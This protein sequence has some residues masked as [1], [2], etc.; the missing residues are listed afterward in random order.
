MTAAAQTV[1]ALIGGKWI[2]LKSTRFVEVFNP[3]SG[4]VLARTPLGSTADA[5]AAVSAAAEALPAWS[6]TPAVDR[7]RVMFAYRELLNRHHDELARLVTREHGKTH[8]EAVAE[9]QRGLEV[10]EFACGV[11]SLLAG[12]TFPNLAANVDGETNRHPVGVCVGITPYNFPNM[13][14]LWMFPIALVCGNTFVL[15]PSEKVPLSAI[16]LGELLIEAGLPAGVFNIVHGDKVVVDALLSD[17]RVAAVSFVGS[18]DIA[19][20]I[21][22]TAAAH[23]KRVQSAGGAK[24]HLIIMP[25][26]DLDQSVKALAA[27]AFGCAG[28]RCMAGSVA[29]AVGDVGDALVD[30]LVDYSS[31]MTVGP[32]DGHDETEMGPLIN[33]AHRT[34]VAGYLD[35]AKSEGASV[36]L[37]GREIAGKFDGFVLGPCVVDEVTPDMTLWRNEIFGPVLSVVRAQTLDDALAIGRACPFGNGAS[38]F[39]RDGYAARQFKRH[40][41][42]GMIGVNIGVP[43]PMAWLPFTGWNASFFGDLHVQGTEGVLF[44]TRQKMTLTRWFASSAE[45]HHDPVWRGKR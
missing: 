15:K 14:P 34:R 29:L 33:E 1:P 45:S 10:V 41:N 40:F 25:D 19:R 6:E 22:A 37:D 30:Q 11:P 23:G 27:S 20:Y 31:R 17:P 12:D 39:T 8:A 26:A 43:A 18:T 38:I 28:Q 24:N 7:A 42:A 36:R 44:Y 3:S 4:S 2:E 13:V 35:T 9:V 16:R 32:T 21:Y 5:A